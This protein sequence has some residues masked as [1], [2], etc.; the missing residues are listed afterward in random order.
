MYIDIHLH[1]YLYIYIYVYI[2][3]YILRACTLTHSRALDI[4]KFSKTGKKTYKLKKKI[5]FAAN[6][7]HDLRD[8][9]MIHN[10]DIYIYIC[11]VI[12]MYI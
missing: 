6:F 8:I 1:L 10:I 7:T 2:Y 12:Y 9:K 4:L 11:I 3:V 5:K